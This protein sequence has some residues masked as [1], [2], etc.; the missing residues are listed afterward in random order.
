MIIV[1]IRYRSWRRV[2]ERNLGFCHARLHIQCEP[3]TLHHWGTF[4]IGRKM[5]A[6]IENSCTYAQRD[7]TELQTN[8]IKTIPIVEVYWYQFQRK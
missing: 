6:F 7:D 5:S 2:N 3:D 4:Y 1:N 8:L